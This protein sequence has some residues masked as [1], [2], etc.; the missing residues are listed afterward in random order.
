[1][2]VFSSKSMLQLQFLE[3]FLCWGES[4]LGH[5]SFGLNIFPVLLIRGRE[6]TEIG[7]G[8]ESEEIVVMYDYLGKLNLTWKVAVPTLKCMEEFC[9]CYMCLN[10]STYFHPER[11]IGRGTWSHSSWRYSDSVLHSWRI[12]ILFIGNGLGKHFYWQWIEGFLCPT[13]SL[14]VLSWTLAS[15]AI[16]L[17]MVFSNSNSTIIS[18]MSTAFAAD[19]L[20]RK[21]AVDQLCWWIKNLQLT[22][23]VMVRWQ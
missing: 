20:V 21:L 19:G 2:A 17:L 23:E 5:G 13:C 11:S 7:K 10:H 4:D 1:M 9:G 22:D 8:S 3:L 15:E 6:R 12:W 18:L 14:C 16:P